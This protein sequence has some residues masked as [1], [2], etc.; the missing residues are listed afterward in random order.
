MSKYPIILE[1]TATRFSAWSPD[2]PGCIVTGGN[3]EETEREMRDGVEF[4]L[5]GIRR[6]GEPVPEPSFSAAYFEVAA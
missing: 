6:K 3:C 1:E 2:V 4:Q 5:E